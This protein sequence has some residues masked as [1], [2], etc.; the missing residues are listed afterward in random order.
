MQETGSQVDSIFKVKF[1]NTKTEAVTN[2]FRDKCPIKKKKNSRNYA[3]TDETNDM[4]IA[5]KP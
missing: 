4:S 3:N 5:A 1:S 2:V